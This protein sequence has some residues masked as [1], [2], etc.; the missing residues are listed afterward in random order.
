MGHVYN[1]GWMKY[2]LDLSREEWQKYNACC[3]VI[4]AKLLQIQEKISK[5]I[6]RNIDGKK[7]YWY[8]VR[9]SNPIW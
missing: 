2:N 1:G 5:E 8:G 6:R 9:C 4:W 7:R 3:I